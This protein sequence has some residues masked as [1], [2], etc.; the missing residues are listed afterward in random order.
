MNAQVDLGCH[1]LHMGLFSC[2][3]SNLNYFNFL[4]VH[5]AVVTAAVFAPHPSQFLDESEKE[6]LARE[7]ESASKDP[8]SKGQFVIS[9]DFLGCIK[10]IRAK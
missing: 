8:D 10:I 9:A 7:K 5:N 3:I 6:R 4:S 2:C 1:Y